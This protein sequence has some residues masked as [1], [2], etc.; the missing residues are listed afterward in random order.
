MRRSPRAAP[1]NAWDEAD[2]VEEHPSDAAILAAIQ[3]TVQHRSDE[4]D[5]A[6]RS[7]VEYLQRKGVRL[8]MTDDRDE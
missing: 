1:V 7:A 8:P 6:V 3:R 5:A 2:L 4:D